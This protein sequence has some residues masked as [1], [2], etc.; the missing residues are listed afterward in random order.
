MGYSI[1]QFNKTQPTLSSIVL[2]LG[3]ILLVYM[4]TVES[5]PGALP[6]A[7]V[8]VGSIWHWISRKKNKKQI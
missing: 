4:V 7:M 2:V 8:L 6:L 5:E 3:L 1:Y